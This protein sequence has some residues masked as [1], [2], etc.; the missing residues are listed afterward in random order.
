VFVSTPDD[1]DAVVRKSFE[2][3]VGLFV[4]EHSPFAHRAATAVSWLEPLDQEMIVLDVACGA[5]HATEQAA[6]H[7]RQVVGIDL[8][9]ALLQVGA[10][11]LRD[12][13]VDNVLL[14]EGNAT[15]LPF[16]DES[17]DLVMCRTA[18]H[19]MPD[20]ERVVA[21]MAR[22]CR[23]DGRVAVLDMIAPNAD[24]RE[25]FDDVH[26]ALDPSHASALLEAELAALLER[27]VGPLSYGETNGPLRFPLAH[28]IT[29][30][31]DRDAVVS[32]LEDEL[33]GGEV[34]GLEP[35]RENDEIVVSFHF[36]TVHA[37]R[38]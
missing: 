14:Q 13:G 29:D 27:T 9:P 6:P 18:I 12:A 26:R 35:A 4:G 15:A 38:R 31:A 24:V 2:G 37:S 28:I 11:R 20:P 3:Q 25:R 8:T 36:T 22:V 5:A 17:F 19:H 21:E 23:P 1:H 30:V 32:A 16:V 10:Q 7:V 34:S 33:A